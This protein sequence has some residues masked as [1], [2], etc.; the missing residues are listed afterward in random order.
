MC[1]RDRSIPLDLGIE[2]LFS[3]ALLGLRA[4]GFVYFFDWETGVLVRRIDVDA[5]DIIW[6]DNNEL[7][8]V[9][10]AT[11]E[12]SGDEPGAYALAFNKDVCDEAV[13]NGIAADTEEGIDAVSY[14][15][16]D[17]YKR[18][19]LV[20][21]GELEEAKQSILPNIEGLSLIHI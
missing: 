10:N 6:S 17:V 16:L 2:K 5:R 11:D 3:G 20:L 8:T 1:I 14:T 13:A 21:R 15:H 19:T 12:N 7:V 4:N 9:I 18:Q